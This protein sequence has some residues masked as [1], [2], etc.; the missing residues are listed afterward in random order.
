[1][2]QELV[3][4]RDVAVADAAVALKLSE[5]QPIC[6]RLAATLDEAGYV[7]VH[8]STEV[9][10]LLQQAWAV[11]SHKQN[12][13]VSIFHLAYA[14][15]FKAP[16]AGSALAEFLETDVDALAVGC[17]LHILP[18]GVAASPPNGDGVV[19]GPAVG[20]T[21][22]LGE[23]AARANS[24]GR[25]SRVRPN[26]L[27]QVVLAGTLPTHE[28]G[29]FRKAARVGEAR[30]ATVIG[31]R[32]VKLIAEAQPH[33]IIEHLTEVEK[34]T[35][36][37]LLLRFSQ[38]E[39]RYEADVAA[40]NIALASVN[41]RLAAMAERVQ[42]F[43]EFGRRFDVVDAAARTSDQRLASI[44]QRVEAIDEIRR[45]LGGIDDHV[46]ALGETLPRP[47]S[48]GR[49]AAAIAAVLALGIIAGLTLTKFQIDSPLVHLVAGSIR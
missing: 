29:L 11:A 41:K 38:F 26:D 21:R 16:E 17:I 5:A 35:D 37:A 20:V 36:H 39:D 18:L 19:L 47:P 6:E 43:D 22:W 3:T 7:D 15:V 48:G 2:S 30:Y 46:A 14:L 10:L 32:P 12:T 1:M 24:R 23:A 42:P 25:R 31:P 8:F 49:L 40:Q 33:D 4:G 27:V 28:R 45:R 34:G 44:E 13:Q 9:Q